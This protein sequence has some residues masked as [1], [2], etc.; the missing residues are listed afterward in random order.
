MAYNTVIN[1]TTGMAY[2]RSTVYML[3]NSTLLD[4]QSN[5]I[6]PLC[7]AQVSLTPYCST[8]YNVSLGRAV[9]EARCEEP[10]DHPYGYDPMTYVMSLEN[11][12]AGN[13]TILREWPLM[14][15][16]RLKGE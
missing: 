8:V 4:S 2:G 12:T 10:R 3:G 6:Y 16:Q 13:F 1:D 15:S 11:A 5:I 9:L 14:I 7:Q